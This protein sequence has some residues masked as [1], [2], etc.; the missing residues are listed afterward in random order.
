MYTP[1]SAGAAAASF[2][3]ARM[4]DLDDLEVVVAWGQT[5][6]RTPRIVGM[7]GQMLAALTC[8]SRCRGATPTP[9]WHD[10]D[11]SRS[12]RLRRKPRIRHWC[13]V[14]IGQSPAAYS[15]P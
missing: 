7:G 14:A 6:R 2:P 15:R 11:E 13:L 8:W 4:H 1:P 9:P 3:C 5:G 12:E 10:A